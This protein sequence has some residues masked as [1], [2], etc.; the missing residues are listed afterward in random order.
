MLIWSLYIDYRFF[1]DG[2]GRSAANARRGLL[3]HRAL[4]WI[5]I[6]LIFGQPGIVTEVLEVFGR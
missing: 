2:L 5:P 3:L 1:R 6:L 4:T